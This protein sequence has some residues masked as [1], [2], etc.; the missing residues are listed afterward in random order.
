MP[1]FRPFKAF[2]PKQEFA[3][4]VAAKPYDVLSSE[5]A[6]KEVVGNPLSFLH[7]GKPEIDLDPSVDIHHPLVYDKAKENLHKLINDKV[8][9]ED[10][11]PYLYLYSQT[12]NGRTQFGLVGCVNV[13]DY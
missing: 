6:R 7:I 9:V 4:K 10:S 5:E 2:R 12:M 3:D 8:L 11:E 1:Q 13:D